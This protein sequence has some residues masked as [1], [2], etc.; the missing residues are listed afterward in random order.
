QALATGFIKYGYTVMMGTRE[1]AKLSDWKNANGPN[2]LTGSFDKAAE[3]GQIIVLAT[4]GIASHH[5]LRLAGT[6]HLEGKT[7]IDATNPIADSQ[8]TNG[9]IKFFTTLDQ[10]LMEELQAIAP[11]AHFV[12]AFNCV[13]NSLMVDPDFGGTKPTMFICGNSEIAKREVR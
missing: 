8:P 10:S 3:F 2:A 5:A 7:V 4:K 12:K 1:P 9:V 11:N 6:Q 13:G